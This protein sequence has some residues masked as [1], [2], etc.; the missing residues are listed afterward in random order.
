M[1][2]R[3]VV[4]KTRGRGR[5]QAAGPALRP[6]PFGSAGGAPPRGW[7]G[8]EVTDLGFEGFGG[9]GQQRVRGAEPHGLRL[10]GLLGRPA[11]HTESQQSGPTE[12][13]PDLARAPGTGAVPAHTAGGDMGHTRIG[14]KAS[15]PDPEGRP[16]AERSPEEGLGSPASAED[17]QLSQV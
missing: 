5:R 15:R 13:S 4:L 9:R 14:Q 1:G 8:T 10:R 7:C 17:T 12:G 6:G 16:R 2:S 11:V 3:P